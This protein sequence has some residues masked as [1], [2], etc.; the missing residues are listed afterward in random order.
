MALTAWVCSLV[1]LMPLNRTF[2]TASWN[3][4]FKST[5]AVV[6][7]HKQQQ[8]TVAWFSCVLVVDFIHLWYK[9]F[10]LD[11]QTTETYKWLPKPP[12]FSSSI[13]YGHKL[14]AKHV[15]TGA[16]WE[17]AAP[18]SVARCELCPRGES[19]TVRP[20]KPLSWQKWENKKSELDLFDTFVALKKSSSQKH[21]REKQTI[22]TEP[23][24]KGQISIGIA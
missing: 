18:Q 9:M 6:T 24:I 16:C 5:K 12:F 13:V 23:L 8:Q 21:T 19:H 1:S 17:T 14:C 3:P 10:L 22:A 2:T 15:W 11:D 20:W 7:P 4:D